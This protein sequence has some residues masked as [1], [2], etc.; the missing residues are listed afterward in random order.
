VLKLILQA[1]RKSA[2][3]LRQRLPPL[4]DALETLVLDGGMDQSGRPHDPAEARPGQGVTIGIVLSEAANVSPDR[5]QRLR[6]RFPGGLAIDSVFALPSRFTDLTGFETWCAARVR[7][8]LD[9]LLAE[10]AAGQLAA[11]G[12]RRRTEELERS[13]AAAEETFAEFRREPLKLAYR[14]ERAGTYALPLMA[15]DDDG[16]QSLEIHQTLRR[17]IAN[18]RYIDVFF[19]GDS[20]D[21]EGTAR[22]TARAAWSGSCC[23]IVPSRSRKSAGD[24]RSFAAT[25]WT[26]ATRNRCPSSFTWR[27]LISAG[28]R[29]LSRT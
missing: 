8:M 16:P 12:L 11:A 26:A 14:A 25:R 27:D 20:R 3:A 23:A 7:T 24:G 22:F 13:L 2:Q 10:Y 6:D 17:T 15:S 19:N 1:D 9:F 28:S 29:R 5:L 18:I 21:L 4:I